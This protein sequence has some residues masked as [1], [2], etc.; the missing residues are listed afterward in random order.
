VKRPVKAVPQVFSTLRN[1]SVPLEY[2]G[3]FTVQLLF[4]VVKQLADPMFVVTVRR[5]QG[6]ACPAT[7]N[8][9]E[10]SFTQA[11]PPFA[12]IRA[13]SGAVLFW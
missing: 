11:N 12:R 8:R 2:D 7:P 13:K 4:P 10:R 3:V 6:P 5:K 9:N 1:T